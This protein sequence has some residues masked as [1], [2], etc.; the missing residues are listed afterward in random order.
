MEREKTT[1]QGLALSLPPTTVI[2][3]LDRATQYSRGGSDD[4]GAA[5]YWIP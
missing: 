3:R 5:A 2:A 4:R 1:F